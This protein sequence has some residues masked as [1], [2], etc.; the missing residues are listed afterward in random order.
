MAK[1]DK[2][3][4]HQ[5]R[6]MWGN[7]ANEIWW[8]RRQKLHD[9]EYVVTPRVIP[10]RKKKK[11][12]EKMLTEIRPIFPNGLITLTTKVFSEVEN[13]FLSF[14]NYNEMNGKPMNKNNS[15]YI[16]WPAVRANWTLQFYFF[17]T[18]QKMF[19]EGH[20]LR[21]LD[22]GIDTM[23]VAAVTRPNDIFKPFMWGSWKSNQSTG[24]SYYVTYITGILVE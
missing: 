3:C 16:Q 13:I 7:S 4:I 10:I 18:W 15:I 22:W 11:K 9:T 6:V 5:H 8:I 14:K 20:V 12:S 2:I 1:G 23:F 24:H 17:S 19:I 21:L